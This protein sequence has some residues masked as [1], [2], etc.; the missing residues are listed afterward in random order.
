MKKVLIIHPE[1]NAFNNPSIK[2]LIDL[3]QSH[4]V[5]VS[6]RCQRSAAPMANS[7][8]VI[9]RPW[10]KIYGRL[11]CIVFDYFASEL[12]SYALI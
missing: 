2:A 12:I 10:G 6:I 1:G 9:L 11:K 8:G 7:S 3:L 4:G 5:I